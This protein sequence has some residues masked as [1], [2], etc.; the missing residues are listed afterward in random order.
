MARIRNHVSLR[1]V[2]LVLLALCLLGPLGTDLKKERKVNPKRIVTILHQSSMTQLEV[3][4][5][6]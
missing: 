1:T 4:S 2:H 6:L 3:V 5:D